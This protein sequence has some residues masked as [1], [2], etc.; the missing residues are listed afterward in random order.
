MGCRR[1]QI[2]CCGNLSERIWE[3]P[4]PE[5]GRG[6]DAAGT[7]FL[8]R[9]NYGVKKWCSVIDSSAGVRTVVCTGS[10]PGT[11]IWCCAREVCRALWKSGSGLS[12]KSL[13]TQQTRIECLSI[14]DFER[15]T[16]L[17]AAGQSERHARSDR[18]TF[19][20]RKVS[21]PK[22]TNAWPKHS[23]ALTRRFVCRADRI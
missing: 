8:R 9:K 7:T 5:P 23:H 16:A 22:T 13:R 12:P 6:T 19:P 20:D 21:T 2:R 18:A 17:R 3:T 10:S 1:P 4:W 15:P 11:A 14:S